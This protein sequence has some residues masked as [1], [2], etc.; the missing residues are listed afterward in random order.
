FLGRDAILIEAHRSIHEPGVR[1]DFFGDVTITYE[2]DDGSRSSVDADEASVSTCE[3]PCCYILNI[4]NVEVEVLWKRRQIDACS[5]VCNKLQL[6]LKI[7]QWTKK[8]AEI[9]QSVPEC[10]RGVVCSG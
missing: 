3:S 7:W 8:Y 4:T 1:S 6:N 9:S 2:R 5:T 10:G